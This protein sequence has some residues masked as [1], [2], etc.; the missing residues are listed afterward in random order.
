MSTDTRFR[1]LLDDET[2]E[3]ERRALAYDQRGAADLAD[4]WRRRR[5]DLRV[6]LEGTRLQ[7]TRPSPGW[8]PVTARTAPPAPARRC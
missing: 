8:V 5:D 3:A 6:Y 1:R 2:A 4:W 7:Q